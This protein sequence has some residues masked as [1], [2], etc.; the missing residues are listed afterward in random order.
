RL[1]IKNYKKE[2]ERIPQ[3]AQY[4]FMME[5]V[6]TLKEYPLNAWGEQEV[7]RFL[8][9][10]LVRGKSLGTTTA[11]TFLKKSNLYKKTLRDAYLTLGSVELDK[12]IL[13]YRNQ[14]KGVLSFTMNTVDII[15][16]KAEYVSFLA[17]TKELKTLTQYETRVPSL[18]KRK[19]A[20]IS[21][22][23]SRL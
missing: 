21:I 20:I 10:T 23:G 15:F 11:E 19:R 13:R 14:L 8:A 16:N 9:W 6:R 3:E 2:V 22:R 4:D 17:F 5:A 18:Q 1:R 7:S 12:E